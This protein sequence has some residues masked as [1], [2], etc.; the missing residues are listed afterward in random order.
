MSY[1]RREKEKPCNDVRRQHKFKSF[2]NEAQFQKF[3]L[4]AMSL[5]PND[6]IRIRGVSFALS[7]A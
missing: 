1:I 4:V 6:S 7:R 2:S 5:R 3:I